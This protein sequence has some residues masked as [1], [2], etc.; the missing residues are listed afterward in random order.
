MNLALSDYPEASFQRP[1]ALA[2][3][4][5]VFVAGDDEDVRD[6]ILGAMTA[7]GH[8]VIGVEGE[9]ELVDCL[10]IITRDGLRP[11]SLIILDAHAHAPPGLALLERLR[12]DG[13]ETPVIML[14][15]VVSRELRE[16]VEGAGAAVICEKPL[17][18]LAMR[19]ARLR[20]VWRATLRRGA[21]CSPPV[22]RL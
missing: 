18:G 20:A 3:P 1:R 14:A 10:N 8:D 13:W 16:G 11:P 7:D 22:R 9:T 19:S 4:K 17:N 15:F 12:R 5:R 21:P 2:G 6:A